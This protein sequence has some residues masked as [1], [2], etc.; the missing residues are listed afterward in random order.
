MAGN[1]PFKKRYDCIQLTSSL[2]SLD[3]VSVL[4]KINNRL[5]CL[6]ESKQVKQVSCTYSDT[7]HN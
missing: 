5:T 4:C 6:P 2:T 3:S 7:S 1:G